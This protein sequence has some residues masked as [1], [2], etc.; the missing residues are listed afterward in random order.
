MKMNTPKDKMLSM[1]S[2][3][4]IWGKQHCKTL[5]DKFIIRYVVLPY[6]EKIK[7]KVKKSCMKS[8]NSLKS[9]SILFFWPPTSN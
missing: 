3:T 1:L 9:S 6:L 7:L 2:I 8:P 4:K 5:N